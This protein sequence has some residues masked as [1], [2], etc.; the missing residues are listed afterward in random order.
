MNI[1]IVGSRNIFD[2]DREKITTVLDLFVSSHDTII[3]GGATG[4]DTIAREY[5]K[6]H[7]TII[8][9][10]ATGVD[11]I[12]REYAKTRKLLFIEYEPLEKCAKGYKERNSKIADACEVC[13]AFPKSYSRG[14]WD[15][16]NKC[17]KLGRRIFIV[18]I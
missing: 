9:G 14:T 1:A 18:N 13:I 7:D 15:T 3:S 16:L 12:A 10:G 5:A 6:T 4:V 8:S 17:K 2:E 11:T